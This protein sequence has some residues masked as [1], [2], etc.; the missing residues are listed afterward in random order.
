MLNIEPESPTHAKDLTDLL[1]YDSGL[2]EMLGGSKIIT[3]AEFTAYNAEWAIK[4]NAKLYAIVK[5]NIAIGSISLAHINRHTQTASSGYWLASAE[6]GKG[7]ATAAF[8]QIIIEAKKLNLIYLKSKI[9]KDNSASLKIWQ[10]YDPEF[11][12]LGDKWQLTIKI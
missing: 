6:W 1:N 12:D 5:D 3:P 8:K 2:K 7:Y 10:R 4:H 11:E 9:K